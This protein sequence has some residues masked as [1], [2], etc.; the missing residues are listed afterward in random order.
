MFEQR[1]FASYNSILEARSLI[2]SVDEWSKQESLAWSAR[3]RGCAQIRK[4][5]PDHRI[6]SIIIAPN[7]SVLRQRQKAALL[8]PPRR[9]TENFDSDWHRE[10]EKAAGRVEMQMQYGACCAVRIH[11]LNTFASAFSVFPS[12]YHGS[13]DLLCALTL[14]SANLDPWQQQHASKKRMYSVRSTE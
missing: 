9:Q 11:T 3:S 8:R 5:Q 2:G 10:M 13:L 6:W 7:I 14:F 4:S 12:S 1:L